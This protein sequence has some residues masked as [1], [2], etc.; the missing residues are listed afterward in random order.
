MSVAGAAAA[1]PGAR[2]AT[3]AVMASYGA[4]LLL[5]IDTLP[6]W[7]TALAVAALL[8]SA[9]GQG[10][11]LPLP[12]RWI[13]ALFAILSI[14]GVVATFRT[15]NGL[16]AGTALLTAMGALKLL[17]TRARRDRLIV[18]AA[19]FFL[20]LAACLERQSLSRVPL[21]L[22]EA[23]LTC[24][25][26]ALVATPGAVLGLRAALLLSARTLLLA[27]PLA[28]ALFLF[29][30]RLTGS[31]WALPSSGSAATGLGEEMTPGSI[32]RLTDSYESAFRVHFAGAA[33]PVQE[34]YWRGPVLN[35]FDGYTWRRE[36]L[37]ALRPAIE[38]AG[39][40][41]RYRITLEPHQHNWWFALERP[42]STL[43][44][45]V[46][47]TYDDMLVAA[48]PVERTVSYE[49]TS[50]TQWR[51]SGA[52]S[53][54]EQRVD[55]RLPPE[56]NV[57]SLELSERLRAQAPNVEAFVQQVLELFRHGG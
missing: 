30:P 16:S 7:C 20:L 38:Y 21:Y 34:R 50:Q 56:R 51:T 36:R 19:A 37:Y 4:G 49:L 17:E 52:L 6:L 41:Y 57:R 40:A 23:W 15:L 8:W 44:A 42:V 10:H 27:L 33:P 28:A 1:D 2:V 25:A 22:G 43:P 5:H 13:Q 29:F 39:E 55:T 46:Y 31:F 35:D 24:A 18:I 48:L 54:V 14:A 11:A 9:L 32:T 45:N 53:R 47:R 3:L 26:L 12:S